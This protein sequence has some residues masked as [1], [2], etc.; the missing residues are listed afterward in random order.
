MRWRDAR[1][2]ALTPAPLPASGAGKSSLMRWRDTGRPPVHP[3]PL[4]VHASGQ[5]RPPSLMRWRDA[6]RPCNR[7]FVTGSWTFGERRRDPRSA[8]KSSLAPLAGAG[9]MRA[10]PPQDAHRQQRH[11]RHKQR[12]TERR[13][14]NSRHMTERRA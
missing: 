10:G 9:E 6:Q 5:R 2:P 8:S 3:N 13:L 14:Q 7:H 1:L 11:T 12:A 4:P